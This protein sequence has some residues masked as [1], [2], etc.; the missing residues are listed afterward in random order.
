MRE[1]ER[2]RIVFL[3]IMAEAVGA[4]ATGFVV[5][6][7]DPHSLFAAG[8]LACVFLLCAMFLTAL[9]VLG[10]DIDL[11]QQ[12]ILESNNDQASLVADSAWVQ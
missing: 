1:R 4:I 10:L 11:L 6:L 3:W 9:L 2:Q 7:T 5:C 8:Y 12:Q